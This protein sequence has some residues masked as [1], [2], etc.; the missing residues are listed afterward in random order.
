MGDSETAFPQCGRMW[1]QLIVQHRGR[2]PY[3]VCTV[4]TMGHALIRA[5]CNLN[6]IIVVL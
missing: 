5:L 4:Y 2:K 6:D 3:K 1:P